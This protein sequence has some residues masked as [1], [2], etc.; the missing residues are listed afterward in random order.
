MY[1]KVNHIGIVVKDIDT[2]AKFYVECLGWKNEGLE[3]IPDQKVKVSFFTIGE[4]RIELVQPTEEGTGVYKFLE[5]K[6]FKDT[7][8]HIAFEVENLELE[9][10]NLKA[11]GVRLIDEKPRKGAHG[12]KIAFLHPKAS[13]GVLIEIC[14]PIEKH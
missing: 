13:N 10:E 4:T 9:L 1:K 12:M 5:E 3:E 7:V 14:E 11:K 6:G 8:H 2:S